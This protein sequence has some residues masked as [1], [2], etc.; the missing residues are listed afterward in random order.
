[1]PCRGSS[2]NSNDNQKSFDHIGIINYSQML[3]EKIFAL[4]NTPTYFLSE[5]F[6]VYLHFYL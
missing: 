4:Q 5:R 3:I 2:G 6:E 1:M